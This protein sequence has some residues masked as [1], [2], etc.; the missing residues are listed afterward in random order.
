ML[1][2][3][4]FNSVSQCVAGWE[5]LYSDTRMAFISSPWRE[6]F[7]DALVTFWPSCNFSLFPAT[8][9][10]KLEG[11]RESEAD[12]PPNFAAF[13]KGP[14]INHPYCQAL[15]VPWRG[16]SHVEW[17][18]REHAWR[19]SSTH[20]P[21]QRGQLLQYVKIFFVIPFYLQSIPVHSANCVKAYRVH[22]EECSVALLC[23]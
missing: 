6:E 4:C 19:H 18:Q 10:I 3:R 23:N 11:V 14:P 22:V 5:V 16:R 15:L 8:P 7:C 21:R 1:V 20:R 12:L 9:Q 2:R 13:Q 17:K